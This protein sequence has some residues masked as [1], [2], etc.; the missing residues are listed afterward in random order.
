MA[1]GGATKRMVAAGEQVAGRFLCRLL[2]EQ[3]RRRRL[4]YAI[5]AM[6]LLCNIAPHFYLPT[7]RHAL[8]CASRW[9][10]IK[11]ARRVFAAL[12]GLTYQRILPTFLLSR[13]WTFRGRYRVA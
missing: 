9:L 11:H 13:R 8:R 2:E 12:R 4:V 3:A 10:A 7:L 1:V 5:A 6:A